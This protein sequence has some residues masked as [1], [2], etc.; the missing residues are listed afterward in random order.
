[1]QSRQIVCIAME[2]SG[3]SQSDQI[4][5]FSTTSFQSEENL[6]QDVNSMKINLLRRNLKTIR[7]VNSVSGEFRCL[8]KFAKH[9]GNSASNDG[10]RPPL[11][12]VEHSI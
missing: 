7:F 6:Y 4:I 12:V 9:C 5:S 10:H 2:T 11:D 3:H 1:M 8:K